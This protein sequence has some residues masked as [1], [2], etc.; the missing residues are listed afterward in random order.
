MAKVGN[1]QKK[2]LVCTECNSENYLKYVNIVQNVKSIQCIKKRN[3][4]NN[5]ARNFSILE[6]LTN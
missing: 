3:S 4:I 1:R 6:L 2:T 5:Y